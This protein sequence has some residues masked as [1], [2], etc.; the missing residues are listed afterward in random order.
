MTYFRIQLPAYYRP[1]WG[2]L[3]LCSEWE[4]VVPPR[5]NHQDNIFKYNVILSVAKNLI[6]SFVVLLLGMTKQF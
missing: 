3:L 4:E 6:R 5:T 1:R 2:V